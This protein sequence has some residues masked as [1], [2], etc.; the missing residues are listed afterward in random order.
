M[1]LTASLMKRRRGLVDYSF[2]V[3]A[4]NAELFEGSCVPNC[5][6]RMWL[7]GSVDPKEP[8]SPFSMN[9]MLI[10]SPGVSP[11]IVSPPRTKKRTRWPPSPPHKEAY[12]L[13]EYWLDY[14]SPDLPS[15]QASL[16]QF[17]PPHHQRA[18]RYLSRLLELPPDQLDANRNCI[19]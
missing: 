15:N 1:R 19:W 7:D 3:A 5:P 8:T 10:A 14:L 9:A 4:S 17:L 2:I 12:S 13:H 6:V 16:N 18:R 11:T